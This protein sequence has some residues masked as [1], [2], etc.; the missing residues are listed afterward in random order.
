MSLALAL[1]GAPTYPTEYASDD[2]WDEPLDQYDTEPLA[3]GKLDYQGN[4]LDDSDVPPHKRLRP[5]SRTIP[6]IMAS[7][8]LVPTQPNSPPPAHMLRVSTHVNPKLAL[9]PAPG[10]R[11][12]PILTEDILR[13][14][15]YAI[16]FGF[17]TMGIEVVDGWAHLHE[18][19][20]AASS[21]RNDFAGLTPSTL[22]SIIE[23]DES[24]R[25]WLLGSCVR[26][27]PRTDRRVDRS[28]ML[29]DG[30]HDSAPPLADYTSTGHS[31]AKKSFARIVAE[32]HFALSECV[33][34]YSLLEKSLCYAAESQ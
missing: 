28:P 31:P 16:R 29:K 32:C 4:R 3:H 7:S 1:F 20:K 34:H 30:Y 27:I 8:T 33:Y 23:H 15:T 13:W 22:R 9:T 19:A 5:E 25:W 2:S 10:V 6:P 17:R 24:G 18:L 14:M 11:E 12:C 26:I 21:D